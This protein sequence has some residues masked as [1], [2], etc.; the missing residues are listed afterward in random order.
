MSAVP[1][2][3]PR[4]TPNDRLGLTLFLALALHALIILG[5]TFKTRDHSPTPIRTLDVILVNTKSAEAP[6]TP[7]YLAQASQRGGGEEQR[8]V[9]PQ[10]NKTT[11]LPAKGKGQAPMPLPE[12]HPKPSPPAPRRVVTTTGPSRESAPRRPKP[13][14]ERRPDASTLISRSMQIASLTAELNSQVQAAASRKRERWITAANTRAYKYAAYMQAWRQKV[15]RIGN[16]NYP[17][18]ARRENLSGSLLL[19]VAIRADGSVAKITLQ[20]SS[21]SKVLD[22]AA[23]RIVRLAAPFSPFPKD[24]RAETDILHITRTWQFDAGNRFSSR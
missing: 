12:A 14:L 1:A 2:S 18:D 24:I 21:G 19:D 16:L 17:D 13:V 11:I 6:K 15:E 5:I 7:D 20:R 8:R 4:I 23:I 3:P 22:D 10:E 9:R